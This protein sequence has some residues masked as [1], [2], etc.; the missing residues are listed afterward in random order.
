MSLPSSDVAAL[1]YELLPGFVTAWVFFGFT[2]HR[3]DNAFEMTII[4]LIFTVIVRAFVACF[5]FATVRIG[6][7]IP[8]FVWT[9][10]G[11]LVA[12]VVIAAMTGF[13][14]A[15]A[16][17]NGFPHDYL[18]DSVTRRTS[19]ASNWFQTFSEH[20][21]YITL[22]L[23]S[24]DRIAGWPELWPDSP[25]AGYFKLAQPF[26]L[27]TEDER[28]TTNALEAL[29][30]SAEEVLRVELWAENPTEPSGASK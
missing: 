23:K 20:D 29:L 21:F 6:Q 2:A 14:F 4:A 26:Y 13:V 8:L 18:P 17:N 28:N 11:E 10:N 1:I 30:I 19:Y 9:V 25:T 12:S 24:G 15:F 5:V 27:D 3:R 7:S 22:H 16:A